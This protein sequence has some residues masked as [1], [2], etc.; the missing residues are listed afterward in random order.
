MATTDG[1]TLTSDPFASSAKNKAMISENLSERDDLFSLTDYSIASS[2]YSD[3]RKVRKQRRVRIDSRGSTT[4]SG[5]GTLD[6]PN[7]APP[8][9][10]PI[11]ETKPMYQFNTDMGEFSVLP[12][13]DRIRHSG[14]IMTRFSATSI[15][16]KKWRQNFWILYEEQLCFF[17]SKEDFEEWLLNPHLSKK[18]RD[19]LMKRNLDFKQELLKMYQIDKKRIKYY[20]KG[21]HMY[22]TFLCI[23]FVI[24]SFRHLLNISSL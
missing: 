20:R 11:Y 14:Y 24:L 21:G 19:V 23:I 5:T 3:V 6:D 12:S 17:R 10:L 2:N 9:I 18:S 1:S 16:T 22:V 7:F 15:L 4:K 13:Y 8:P